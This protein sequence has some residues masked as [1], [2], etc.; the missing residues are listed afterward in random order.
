MRTAQQEE[1][2]A[3]LDAFTEQKEST[4]LCGQQLQRK[5]I[6]L[7]SGAEETTV[8][9]HLSKGSPRF[10]ATTAQLQGDLSLV[11]GICVG[12]WEHNFSN[13]WLPHKAMEA[14]L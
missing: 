6:G 1:A 14:G 9:G 4:A 13:F 11:L 5:T 8:R 7:T 2:T 3:A 10:N 12:T